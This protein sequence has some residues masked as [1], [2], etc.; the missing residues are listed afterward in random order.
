MSILVIDHYDSFVYNLVQLV[1][2]FGYETEV[3]RSD[4]ETTDALL[5][6]RPERVDD[7]FALAA[8]RGL[9]EL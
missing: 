6:R 4:A 7:G 8:Q 2:G 5:E 1:E 3:V 9:I